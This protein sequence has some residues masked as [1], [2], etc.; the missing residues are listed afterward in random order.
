[1]VAGIGVDSSSVVV[2]GVVVDVVVGE[3]TDEI[4]LEMVV[5]GSWKHTNAILLK[6]SIQFEGF[7]QRDIFFEVT[8]R[9]LA[10]S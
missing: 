5:V 8:R 10:K 3:V 6:G 7:L 9:N 1:M 4:T 2:L